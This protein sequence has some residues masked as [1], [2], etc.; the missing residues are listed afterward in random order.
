MQVLKDTICTS[1][2]AH[3]RVEATVNPLCLYATKIR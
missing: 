3:Y 2:N 1:N